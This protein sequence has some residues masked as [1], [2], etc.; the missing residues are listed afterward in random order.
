MFSYRR[1]RNIIYFYF[2]LLFS[3]I[4]RKHS[5]KLN[6]RENTVCTV[7]IVLFSL[8]SIYLQQQ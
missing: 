3:F 1:E 4:I 6:E 2:Y 5:S 8:C 7:L